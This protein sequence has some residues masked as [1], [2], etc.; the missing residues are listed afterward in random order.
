MKINLQFKEKQPP[1]EILID[2]SDA[3]KQEGIYN[4]HNHLGSK[5]NHRLIVINNYT[6]DG[7]NL[8]IFVD[9]LSQTMKYATIS[10]LGS[11]KFS[12]VQDE[13]INLTFQKK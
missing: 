13:E 12:K 5:T 10:L 1:E 4:I 7:V 6:S 9:Y 2:A 3:V 8:A 11:Y